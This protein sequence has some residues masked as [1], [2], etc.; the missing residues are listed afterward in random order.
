MGSDWEGGASASLSDV[1][2]PRLSGP[3]EPLDETVG[4]LPQAQAHQQHSGPTWPCKKV[5][6][7]S[8]IINIYIDLLYRALANYFTLM[9][10]TVVFVPVTKLTVHLSLSDNFALHASLP[11]ALPHCPGRRHVQ[12]TLECIPDLY[13]P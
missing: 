1:P 13:L 8:V 4:V 2:A 12:C 5:L 10:L 7:S 3:W 11:P 6:S 9:T